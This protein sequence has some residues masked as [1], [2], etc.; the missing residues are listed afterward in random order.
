MNNNSLITNGLRDRRTLEK[1]LERVSRRVPV[2]YFSF[3]TFPRVCV[4]VCTRVL[5]RKGRYSSSSKDIFSN[6]RSCSFFFFFFLLLIV[7][8][9]EDEEEGSRVCRAPP[10]WRITCLLIVIY[11]YHSRPSRPNERERTDAA[12]NCHWRTASM[13][14]FLIQD[15]GGRVLWFNE[16][17]TCDHLDRLRL[18]HVA[19]R[20]RRHVCPLCDRPA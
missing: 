17:G 4:C 3:V 6:L 14:C 8:T 19:R 10:F 18:L 16:T 1:Y 2:D 7:A 15:G 13:R 20:R 11:R 5:L 9:E 12:V